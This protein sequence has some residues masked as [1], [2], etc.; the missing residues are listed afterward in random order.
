MRQSSQQRNDLHA[1][2]YAAGEA[3]PEARPVRRHPMLDH[4][5][6]RA[7]EPGGFA[8]DIARGLGIATLVG[9]VLAVVVASWILWS[10]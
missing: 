9:V 6:G 10:F 3:K 1:L 4:P 7:A 5:Y 8:R 2:R